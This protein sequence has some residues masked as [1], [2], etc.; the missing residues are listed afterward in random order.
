MSTLTVPQLD[1]IHAESG[2]PGPLYEVSSATLQIIYDDANLGASDLSRTIYFALSR[3]VALAS[4]L[5]DKSNEVD[6]LS[7]RSS[8]KFDHLEKL[9]ARWGG[10][11]GLGGAPL[12]AG[13]I[14]LHLDTT[15]DD[16]MADVQ[17]PNLGW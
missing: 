13:I 5:V 1:Y 7:V 14:S 4:E 17:N 11:T 3:R 2:E 10:I 15:C 8:Q 12:K 6:N 16:I 9:L